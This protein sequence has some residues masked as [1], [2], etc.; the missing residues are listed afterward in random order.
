MVECKLADAV[1]AL[2][3]D[4]ILNPGKMGLGK[5]GLARWGA[6]P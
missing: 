4:G 3:P 1:G 6:R 2:V 5:V